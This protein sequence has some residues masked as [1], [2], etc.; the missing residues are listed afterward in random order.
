MEPLPFRLP[1]PGLDDVSGLAVVSVT[2]RVEGLAHWTGEV[3]VLEWAETHHVDEVSFQKVRSDVVVQPSLTV[4]VPPAVLA[5]VEVTG[6]WWRPR[7]ELRGRYLDLFVHIP[8]SRP[9]RLPL[10]IAR[11]DR[12]LARQLA[13]EL[14]QAIERAAPLPSDSPAAALEPSNSQPDLPAVDYHDPT[15]PNPAA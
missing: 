12:A 14:N 4:D 10:R 8:G 6:G 13:A 9:G 5:G 7:L 2:V 1:A 11:R 3:L 15:T